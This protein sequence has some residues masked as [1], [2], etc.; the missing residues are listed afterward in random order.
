MN[1]T[2]N[3]TQTPRATS[4]FPNP[5]Q[6]QPMR[7]RLVVE[8]DFRKNEATLLDE[9]LVKTKDL[10]LRKHDCVLLLSIS[11]K[12]MKFVFGFQEF[13]LVGANGVSR[14]RLTRVLRSMTYR[15]CSG[16]TWNPYMLKN[17]AAE[18]GIDLAHIKRFEQYYKG[19]TDA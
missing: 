19:L 9:L 6:P 13:D 15:I 4:A 1:T 17:Y 18:L 7:L 5:G 2:Q 11:G 8:A 3:G 14:Q 12:M 16:G 10:E